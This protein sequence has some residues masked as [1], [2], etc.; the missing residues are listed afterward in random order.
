MMVAPPLFGAVQVTVICVLPAVGLGVGAG[1]RICIKS[2]PRFC[3]FAL[4]T[5]PDQDQD[6][7]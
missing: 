3:F 1:A 2:Q 4:T 6:N 7:N 5:R